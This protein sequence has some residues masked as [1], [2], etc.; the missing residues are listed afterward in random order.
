MAH[1]ATQRQRALPVSGHA[2]ASNGQ[3]TAA[4][5][6]PRLLAG[7]WGEGELLARATRANVRGAGFGPR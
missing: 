3:A 2:P 5:A 1:P 7:R 6:E 4:W